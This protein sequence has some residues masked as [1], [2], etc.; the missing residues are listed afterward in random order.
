MNS[1]KRTSIQLR[2][3]RILK[4]VINVEIPY[5]QRDLDVQPERPN[6]NT[7]R[8]LVILVACATGNK[9]HIRRKTDHLRPTN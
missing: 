9:R 3:I 7:A 4:Y 2:S 5:T 6:A 1:P 8:S